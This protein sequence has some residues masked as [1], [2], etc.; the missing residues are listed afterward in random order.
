MNAREVSRETERLAAARG[1][2][3]GSRLEHYLLCLL[4]ARED[5]RSVLRS[6]VQAVR[7]DLDRLDK[8]LRADSPLLNT[9]GELQQRPA[10][11]EARVGEFAAADKALRVFLE[12][13]PPGRRSSSHATG[14]RP[15]S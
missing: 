15:S 3:A 9:L 1:W 10:A 5:A 14:D 12:T 6:S 11:V 8:M 7:N 2:E 13:F 4:S